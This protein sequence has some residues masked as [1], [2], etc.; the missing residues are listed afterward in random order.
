M[1]AKPIDRISMPDDETFF[2]EYVFKRKPVIITNLFDG[3]EIREIQSLEQ[4]RKAFGPVKL[5]VNF[6]CPKPGSPATETITFNEF[7]DYVKANPSTNLWCSEYEI[8]ARIMAQFKLPSVCAARSQDEEE[9]LSL[10]RKYGDHDLSSNLFVANRGFSAN[11]HWDGDHRQVILYQAFGRKKVILFQPEGGVNLKPLDG[12]VPF[13]GVSLERMTEAEKLAF[14]DANDGYY[15]TIYPTEAIYMPMLIWHQLEYA[16]DAMSFN[17]RF[18]RN[19]YGRFLCVDNFH[20]D[21]YTQCFASKLADTTVCER[22][23]KTVTD[24][25]IN[26]YLEPTTNLSEKIKDM[27]KLFKELCAQIIPEARMEEYCPPEREQEEI[28]KI[29]KDIGHT[30]RYTDPNIIKQLRPVGPITTRQKELIEK[31]AL[32]YGYPPGA[33]RHLLLNRLG[34][35]DV[36]TLTKVEAAHF[37]SHLKSPGASWPS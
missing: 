6:G 37:L 13:C 7:W 16:D 10:P 35:T 8:P 26:K 19:K 25:V 17:I 28:E 33:L 20:R 18:G 5:A 34:K 31:N 11:L 24:S 15:G 27:R 12:H 3:E 32:K 14:V 1:P 30:M 2:R 9:I 36:D 29:I 23:Y 22:Q 4:A 21:Y